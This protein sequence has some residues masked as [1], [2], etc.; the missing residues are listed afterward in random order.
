M[1]KIKMV[2]N[3]VLQDKTGSVSSLNQLDDSFDSMD[4]LKHRLEEVEIEKNQLIKQVYRG[5]YT[6]DHFI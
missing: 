3:L 6:R 4:K 5:S 1:R 2:W